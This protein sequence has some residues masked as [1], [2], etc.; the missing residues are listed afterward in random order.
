MEESNK[1]SHV[2]GGDKEILYSKAIKAGKRIYY[3]DVKKNLKDD[4]FL[5]VTE[6][7][8]VQ[9]KDGAQVTFEKHKIFLYKEDFEKFMDGM[10]EVINYIKQRNQ[11]MDSG[12]ED[13]EDGSADDIKLDID[14]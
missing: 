5:A 2:E 14:F 9:S 4:L 11:S 12:M 1:K 10:H 3:L 6:S 8:K 7:K 13:G